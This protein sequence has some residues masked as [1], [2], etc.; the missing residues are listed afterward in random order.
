MTH[1]DH[2]DRVAMITG[3]AHGIGQSIA[4]AFANAGARV[5]IADR[6]VA[7]AEQAAELIASATGAELIAVGVDVRNAAE[8]TAA[9]AQALARFERIDVLVNN[10]GIYPN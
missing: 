3:G 7:A 9:V 5:V 10:A 2:R 6:Q 8:V 4:R 1:T